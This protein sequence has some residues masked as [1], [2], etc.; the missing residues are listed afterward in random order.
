MNNKQTKEELIETVLG[1]L[2]FQV[3]DSEHRDKM[4]SILGGEDEMLA[5]EDFLKDRWYEEADFYNL[6]K[7]MY[8]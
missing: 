7:E 5:L 2:T 6:V 3:T 4:K 1:D 8:E